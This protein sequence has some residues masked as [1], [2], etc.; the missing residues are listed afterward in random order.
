MI[1][2]DTPEKVRLEQEKIAAKS[3]NTNKK[4][5]VTRKV[6]QSDEEDNDQEKETVEYAES[7][8]DTDWAAED[9]DE[10]SD[11]E[12]VI[13]TERHLTKSLTRAPLEGEYVI[14]QFTTKKLTSLYVGK[15]I[16][17]RN[18]N[19]EFYISFLRRTPGTS[20]FHMPDK[21]DLSV[22]KES[23]LKLL[24]PKPSIVGTSS[25][26]YYNFGLDLS[27]LRIC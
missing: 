2:T 5:K 22:I 3:K 13:I 26:P 20:K 12:S 23:D 15:V 4:G 16:E 19:N 14:V 8:D 24:L 11:E 7:D 21:P 10:N 27:Q 25:R 1:L 9:E 6:L 18:E 17:G